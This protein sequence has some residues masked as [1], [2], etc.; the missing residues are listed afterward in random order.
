MWSE[1]N[2]HFAWTQF[3]CSVFFTE[4]KHPQLPAFLAFSCA[5]Y[6]TVKLK[7]KQTSHT[8]TIRKQYAYAYVAI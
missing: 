7:D 8:H 3:G 6:V 5:L 4:T 2:T 1:S